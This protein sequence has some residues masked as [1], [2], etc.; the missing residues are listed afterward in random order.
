LIA[1]LAPPTTWRIP[2]TVVAVLMA[3]TITGAVS[4]GL[5]GAPKLRAVLRNVIGGSLALAV[6]Y[7][8]G[9]L[10]GDAIG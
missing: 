1:I 5:G 10:V 7:A 8:I 4:A 3:L 9:H 6:T 2:V